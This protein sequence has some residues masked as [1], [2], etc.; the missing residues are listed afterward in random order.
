MTSKY[1]KRGIKGKNLIFI[2]NCKTAHQIDMVFLL[3]REEN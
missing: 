1:K 2:Y 3:L